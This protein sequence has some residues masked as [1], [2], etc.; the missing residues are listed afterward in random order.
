MRRLWFEF[1]RRCGKLWRGSAR[2]AIEFICW[3]VHRIGIIRFI[4]TFFYVLRFVIH[5]HTQKTTKFRNQQFHIGQKRIKALKKA[6]TMEMH[7]VQKT[8]D[9]INDL[10]TDRWRLCSIYSKFFLAKKI[11]KNFLIT[12]PKNCLNF[13]D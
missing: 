12:K 10:C 5:T 2:F 6:N 3:N 1:L 8:R 13:L 4:F 11:P 9:K 7:A